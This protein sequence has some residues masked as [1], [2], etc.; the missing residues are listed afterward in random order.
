MKKT[1]FYGAAAIA[2]LFVILGVYYL[3]PGVYHIVSNG[4]PATAA[5]HAHKRYAV[6]FFVLAVIG[7]AGALFTRPKRA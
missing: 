6:V 4:G 5:M 1:L 3:I 7:I 2:I